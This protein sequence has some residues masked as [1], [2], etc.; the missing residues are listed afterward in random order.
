MDLDPIPPAAASPPSPTA[1]RLVDIEASLEA[2]FQRLSLAK[3]LGDNPS[4]LFAI[5]HGL[6][7]DTIAS[8][9]NRLGSSLGDLGYMSDKHLLTWVVHATE[10][11]YR[12]GGLE[13]WDTF[14]QQTPN[15]RRHNARETLR[16][17]FQRFS[18]KYDGINPTGGWAE[19]YRYICW[20]IAHALLPRDLQLQLAHAIYRARYYLYAALRQ[21][22]EALGRLV[23]QH[24]YYPTHRFSLFL[25]GHRMVGWIVRAL[26]VGDGEASGIEP[27]ALQRIVEDLRR[28]GHTRA[29]LNDSRGVYQ[30]HSVRPYGGSLGMPSTEWF[31][32]QPLPHRAPREAAS[33]SQREPG[34]EP[35]LTL[36]RTAESE[37]TAAINIPSFAALT[38]QSDQLAD[39]LESARVGVPAHGPS[40]GPAAALLS[41]SGLNRT[42]KTW[43]TERTCVLR[44]EQTLPVFD[45]LVK[46]SCQLQPASLWLFRVRSDGTATHVIGTCVRPGDRYVIVVREAAKLPA[47]WQPQ[48]IKCEGVSAAIVT[49]P[50]PVGEA[51]TLRLKQAGLSSALSVTVAPVGALPIGWS[52]QSLGEWL[53]TQSPCFLLRRD[54]D[55][56]HYSVSLDGQSAT[57]LACGPA[58]DQIVSL[59]GLS[60]GHHVLVIGTHTTVGQA[61]GRTKLLRTVKLPIV[62]RQPRNWV[63]GRQP[64]QA[65]LVTCA[66]AAPT[67]AEFL[68]GRVAL[69][70]DGDPTQLV[71]VKLDLLD[72][73]GKLIS[74]IPI[75]EQRLPVDAQAWREALGGALHHGGD[76]LD[77][78]SFESAHIVVDGGHLGMRRI[79][80]Q[81]VVRPLR[82]MYLRDPQ[83]A[84]LQL[85]DDMESSKVRVRMAPFNSPAQWR[86]LQVQSS[87]SG[88]KVGGDD[89]LYVAVNNSEEASVIVSPAVRGKGIDWLRVRINPADLPNNLRDTLETYRVWSSA[90]VCGL[91]SRHRQRQ[92]L[93]ILQDHGIGLITG[94]R[95]R[96]LETSLGESPTEADWERLEES[97][98]YGTHYGILLSK[99]WA[100]SDHT[101]EGLEDRFVKITMQLRLAND[102]GAARCAWRLAG[103]FQDIRAS[104]A[105]DAWGR[106]HGMLGSSMRGA[107]LLKLYAERNRST[108]EMEDACR[109]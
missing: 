30:Q 109:S 73:E 62:I 54:H 9:G 59:K 101:G 79:V 3:R 36:I 64:L 48:R 82:W 100:T 85:V 77:L 56:T 52:P 40:M 18:Q 19:N 50:D 71:R 23:A 80:L 58:G 31:P 15:W 21:S 75:C 41:P 29:W 35:R 105:E 90:R 86:P 96:E 49:I 89:G 34:L 20:P 69:R 22:E 91:V 74:A 42:L 78:L 103:G 33:G 28:D 70:L 106:Y 17:F 11:G 53:S 43:P 55:F 25:R 88:F 108:A 8:L 5:E 13:Y 94:R 95:W 12:F 26:L 72:A 1:T 63:V 14:A 57:T 97:A 68:A 10:R 76:D 47:L 67:F 38:S 66:P 84:E 24:S 4:P 99:A 104:D 27:R 6:D 102:P 44:F 51:F 65:M 16:S 39:H 92:V 46:S 45:D 98:H 7:E 83:K 93:R 2:H 32:D 107:R 87:M 61:Y 81:Q 60:V 37:W